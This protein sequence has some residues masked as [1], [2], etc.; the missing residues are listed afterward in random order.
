M[1][2]N[3]QNAYLTN[4]YSVA[5]FRVFKPARLSGIMQQFRMDFFLWR[6]SV[7]SEDYSA[8]IRFL[9]RMKSADD[10]VSDAL[11]AQLEILSF[12]I[13]ALLTPFYRISQKSPISWHR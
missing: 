10:V 4:L 11:K 2:S 9:K 13:I 12:D 5:D 8:E 7:K 1:R 6:S 3:P